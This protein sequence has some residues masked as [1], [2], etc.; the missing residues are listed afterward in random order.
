MTLYRKKDDGQYPLYDGD[1]ELLYPG[2]SIEEAQAYFDIIEETEPPIHDN[3][4]SPVETDLIFEDGK[5]KRQWILVQRSEED[6]AYENNLEAR[7][8]PFYK[9]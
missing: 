4:M 1:I 2:M 8:S 6:I 3:T 7:F 5:W 9:P